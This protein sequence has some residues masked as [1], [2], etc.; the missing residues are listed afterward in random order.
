M[1]LTYSCKFYCSCC[2]RDF[3]SDEP[4]MEGELHDQ[5][6]KLNEILN[7]LRK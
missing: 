6:H 1:I 4:K 2:K 3:V 7:L 5:G